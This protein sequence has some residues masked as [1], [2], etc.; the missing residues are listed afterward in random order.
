[1][2]N[3][4]KLFALKLSSK[5]WQWDK[6]NMFVECSES[7][8]YFLLLLFKVWLKAGEQGLLGCNTPEEAGGLGGDVLMSAIMWEEQ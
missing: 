3:F 6:S 7:I 1:M 2:L 4:L 8:D 5:N